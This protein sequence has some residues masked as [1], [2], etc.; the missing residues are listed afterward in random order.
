MKQLMMAALAVVLV[1]CATTG[2]PSARG[3]ANEIDRAEIETTSGVT[4]AQDLV[5]RLRPQWLRGRGSV[6]MNNTQQEAIVVYVD[7]VRSGQIHVTR[8]LEASRAAG[9]NPLEGIAAARVERL[10]YYGASEATQ[11][12]GTG[13]THGA[14]EVITRG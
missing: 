8:T 5:Q 14:I 4:T 12:F 13:H 7:G 11:R 9:P 1:G 2:S 3:S 10:V 6:T